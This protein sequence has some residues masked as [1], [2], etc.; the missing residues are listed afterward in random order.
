MKLAITENYLCRIVKALGLEENIVLAPNTFK[1]LD[2]NDEEKKLN[3]QV[4]AKNKNHTAIKGKF[5]DVLSL[6]NEVYLDKLN[7]VHADSLF[8]AVKD[9]NQKELQEAISYIRTVIDYENNI[10][11]FEYNNIEAILK[12][13]EEI[14]VILGKPSQARQIAQRNRGQLTSL[15]DGFYERIKNKSVLVLKNIEPFEAYGLWVS[16][17]VNKV[18]ARNAITLKDNEHTEISWSDIREMNP[19]TIIVAP[20]NCNLEESLKTFKILEKLPFWH[21]L[22]AVIRTEVYFCSGLSFQDPLR[23]ITEGSLYLV[24][25]IAGLNPGDITKRDSF[26]RLRWVELMRHKL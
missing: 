10:H 18:C 20:E 11:L 8:M 24:S 1:S 14:G 5:S 21:D 2:K 17:L 7:K 4:I 22:P 19:N 26:R 9:K 23:A 15:T 6:E 12:S 13:I 3:F 16:D 25:C